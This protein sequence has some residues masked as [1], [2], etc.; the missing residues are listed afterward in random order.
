MS[1]IESYSAF[2]KAHDLNE[3]P[4]Q[5]K[6]C[7]RLDQYLLEVNK[8]RSNPF[9]RRPLR[10]ISTI[11]K[12]LFGEGCAIHGCYL[13]GDVGRGK[14]ML[15]DLFY[16][17]AK[18]IKRRFHF[19]RMMLDLHQAIFSRQ[20]DSPT[21]VTDKTDKFEYALSTLI[22]SARLICLDEFMINNL[23]DALL[24]E[25]FVKH[26]KRKGGFCL[27]TSNTK[28]QDLYK[29]GLN[30]E[31]FQPTIAWIC[32]HYDQI[33]LDGPQDYRVKDPLKRTFYLMKNGDSV[34][35]ELLFESHT[36]NSGHPLEIAYDTGVMR[37]PK[38]YNG[39]AMLPFETL[40]GQPK[41]A[42]DYY[43]LS[44]RIHSLLLTG[45]RPL[46]CASPS[47]HRL[48]TL[49]DVLYETRCKL[50]FADSECP[51]DAVLIGK[52]SNDTKFSRML[53]RLHEML[54][55]NYIDAP[56]KSYEKM[57]RL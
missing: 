49:I 47:A 37:I 20:A 3:D 4:D 32:T 11:R 27:I 39:F 9:F 10:H 26:L 14:T 16:E 53:S 15:M 42:N 51:L 48:V 31:L 6:I 56:L 12:R 5:K 46:D 19:N 35:A 22:G 43:V 52:P 40:C 57:S 38:F 7:L 50:Y 41:G 18:C 24:V 13:Y 33:F 23:P 30:R 54:T 17:Q 29:H 1:I 55:Q 25:K 28:P 36:Q 44:A 2:I 34:S 21:K 45:L 8:S